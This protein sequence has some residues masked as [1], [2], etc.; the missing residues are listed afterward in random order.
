MRSLLKSMFLSAMLF[1]AIGAGCGSA[2]A[3]S[4]RV[5]VPMP[6]FPATYKTFTSA[7]GWSIKYPGEW[8]V[9]ESNYGTSGLVSFAAP[10]TV[11]TF[12][13][14]F[15]VTKT[16]TTFTADMIDY[17]DLQGT[18]KTVIESSGGANVVTKVVSLPAGDAVRGDADIVKSN[19]SLKVSQAQ[20]YRDNVGF[21]LNFMSSSNDYETYKAD[22]ELM[23]Q[24]FQ[25]GI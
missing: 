20:M 7:D 8:T 24:S 21:V 22:A 12:P 4:E 11:G 9:D 16:K 25:P 13:P 14:N 19:L 17:A 18:I 3:P 1:L 15:G 5:A 2:G 6:E 23:F 10:A